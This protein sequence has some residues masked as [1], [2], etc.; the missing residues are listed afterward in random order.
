MNFF[1]KLINDPER[2][3]RTGSPLAR[4]ALGLGLMFFDLHTVATG[5]IRTSKAGNGT[6][7]QFSDHPQA[8][9]LTCI[10]AAVAALWALT[11]ARKR[12]LLHDD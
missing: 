3:P 11:S 9:V 4:A 6:Y 1:E 5:A 7:I 8:F 10:G 2:G 12:Y